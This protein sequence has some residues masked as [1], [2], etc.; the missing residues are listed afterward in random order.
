[1]A[2]SLGG[3][4]DGSWSGASDV[5]L[6]N[7]GTI[8]K[9][10]S[11]GSSMF[12]PISLGIYGIGQLGSS[13]LTGNAN[14][15]LAAQQRKDNQQQALY[16]MFGTMTSAAQDR[17]ARA[18]ASAASTLGQF[19]GVLYGD[20]IT[21]GLQE[22]VE[23]QRVG[24]FEPQTIQVE[25]VSGLVQ[26]GE[27][28]AY[29]EALASFQASNLKKAN[30]ELSSFINKYPSSP[31][32]PLALY[33][34][35]NTKYALKD[36]PGAITQLQT[37]MNKYPDHPRIPAATLSLAN[38]QLESGKKTLAKKLLNDLMAKYPDSDSA[39]EAKKIAASLN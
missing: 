11:G 37:L 24:V 34:S 20:P 7:W 36:Y 31:Y 5:G 23:R 28:A 13:F 19:G 39:K 17:A 32:L 33:W 30:T 25:G 15:Q 27:K 8:G 21:A 29:D 10:N 2:F 26:P 22:R 9:S 12:D 14:R 4:W 18:E 3:M 38:A 16:G 35:G 6:G 1:M